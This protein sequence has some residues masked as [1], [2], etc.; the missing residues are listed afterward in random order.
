MFDAEGKLKISDGPAIARLLAAGNLYPIYRLERVLAGGARPCAKRRGKAVPGLDR[1]ASC[2]RQAE[3]SY[4][5]RPVHHS[6][7]QVLTVA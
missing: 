6:V 1:G 2:R 4:L 5:L 7:Q 3:A